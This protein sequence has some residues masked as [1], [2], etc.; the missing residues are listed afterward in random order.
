MKLSVLKELLLGSD[1]HLSAAEEAEVIADIR[2]MDSGVLRLTSRRHEY[3]KLLI[4]SRQRKFVAGWWKAKQAD[5]E[6]GDYDDSR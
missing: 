4:L 3:H 5:T 2:A 6:G 1:N